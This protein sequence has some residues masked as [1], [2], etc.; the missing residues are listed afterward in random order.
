MN[1]EEYVNWSPAHIADYENLGQPPSDLESV[2]DGYAFLLGA[3]LYWIS[4]VDHA[5]RSILVECGDYVS[6][7]EGDRRFIEEIL[8]QP[9]IFRLQNWDTVKRLKDLWPDD[10]QWQRLIEGYDNL[11][12]FQRNHLIHSHP[13][14]LNQPLFRY[15]VDLDRLPSIGMDFETEMDEDTGRFSL[16]FPD[17]PQANRPVHIIWTDAILTEYVQMLQALFHDLVSWTNENIDR[18]TP[19]AREVSI[20][21]KEHGPYITFRPLSN[22]GHDG[23]VSSDDGE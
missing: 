15:Y 2:D 4:Q 16:T 12:V 10:E 9:L 3:T 17:H 6:E 22:L 23:T 20:G 13:T 19:P 5:F 11:V 18:L 21:S 1:P 8:R 14:G 7:S